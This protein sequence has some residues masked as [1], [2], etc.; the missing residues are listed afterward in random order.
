[1]SQSG[2]D[3]T[4]VL[5]TREQLAA[6]RPDEEYIAAVA[7]NAARNVVFAIFSLPGIAGREVINR[8]RGLATVAEALIGFIR[9][10][11]RFIIGII[12]V[13]ALSILETATL[14]VIGFIQ[15]VFGG[16][17]PYATPAT[18][19][20]RGIA[21]YPILFMRPGL[22]ALGA[23]GD[24]ILAALAYL[25]AEIFAA[26]QA[27]GPLAP[28]VHIILWGGVVALSVVVLWRVTIALAAAV[29]L[30][31]LTRLLGGSS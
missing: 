29:N 9:Y 2:D 27:A 21:D 5:V 18:E 28:L 6:L 15:L 17:R 20:V 23:V 14:D 1:M 10:P 11:R 12:G 22:R 26:S 13:S 8:L 4:Y 25:Q 7:R 16:S 3:S 24:R 19:Q 30:D 31:S